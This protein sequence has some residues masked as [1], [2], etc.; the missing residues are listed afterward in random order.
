MQKVY[1]KTFGCRTN[2]YDTQV[3]I[4]AAK[5]WQRVR[6]ES[7]ADAIVIN[8]CTVTNSADSAVRAYARRVRRDYPNAKLLLTGCGAGALGERLLEGGAI[9]GAFGHSEKLR[10][11]SFLTAAEP[12]LRL[13]DTNAPIEEAAIASFAG[14]KR[15][16]IKIQEGCDFACSYCIV[17]TT[18]GRA[19]SQKPQIVLDQI[20]RLIDGGYMEFVLTGTN[21]GGYG[22]DVGSSLS[23]LIAQIGKIDGVK[24]LR[25]GS[26]EPAQIGE[27]LIDL[28]DAP[29][30]AKHLHIA[31]QHTDDRILAA[32]N[33]RNRFE[34]D[35]AL[36]TQIASRGYAIGTDYIAGFPSES[37]AIHNES[38]LRLNDLPLT[39]IHLFR[40]SPREGTEA[41]QMK[42]DVTGDEAA[43]RQV[44]IE[45]AIEA[46]R[47][48]FYEAH[49]RLEVLIE[50][51]NSGFDQYFSRVHFE[52]PKPLSGF[53][54]T[55][56]YTYNKVK[57]TATTTTAQD[58]S[59]HTT[60]S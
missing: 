50:N 10:I 24:R 12:F 14:K 45:A 43:A 29:F 4:S 8:S 34:S 35:R 30:M 19:R 1:F 48:K 37:R 52:T 2:L 51:D 21:T 46:K 55:T 15:A 32:M 59:M 36:L 6:T 33:R 56:N 57:I 26:I 25:L 11:T 38:V 20:R 42:V 41:A 31:L 39:H 18:R 17:P 13:G 23:S 49:R 53:V 27:E 47:A 16:F 40:F 54:P 22:S 58:I 44:E 5:G 7:E 60:L 9:D 28:L 3:M